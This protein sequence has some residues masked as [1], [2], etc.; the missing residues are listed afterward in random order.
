MWMAVLTAAGVVYLTVGF[1]GRR[2]PGPLARAHAR[3]PALTGFNSCAR[4]HG[5]WFG[6]MAE[7]CLECHVD[8]GAQTRRG[9][10]LHGA[11]G[12]EA[13]R[14]AACHS[15]HHGADFPM[16]NRI[17][18]VRAGIENPSH[19]D[20]AL[21][22]W[23][24]AGRHLELS[25]SEC[26]EHAAAAVLPE[27]AK[28]YLGLDRTCAGCHEDP[29]GGLLTQDCARCHRQD[30]FRALQA[31]D[32]DRAL[33]LEGGHAGVTCRTC[34][35]GGEA[36]ALEA[37]LGGSAS[38]RPRTCLDCHRS[39]H[40]EGFVQGAAGPAAVAVDAGCGVCHLAEHSSFRP[41]DLSVTS[42]QHA[43]SG[44]PLEPPHAEIACGACHRPEKEPFGARYPGREAD[45]CAACHADPHD[46]Q[47]R[48]ASCLDCHDRLRF[49]PHGFTAERHAATKLPL[50][51][52]H[53][54]T[55][56]HSCHRES[57]PGR[58]RIFA[59]T[60][61]DCEG[62]HVDAHRGFFGRFA[63]EEEPARCAACHATTSFREALPFD[64]PRWTGFALRGAHAQDACESCHQRTR[65][66]DR[67]GRTFGEVS[68]RFGRVENCGSCHRDV[69]GGRFDGPGRPREVEGRSSCARCHTETSFRDFPGGFDHATWTGFPL[70]GAHG[71]VGCTG[72][73]A[74]LRR[75]DAQGRTWARAQGARCA[76]CH[77]DPHAGQ[78]RVSGVTDCRRC[79]RSAMSFSDLTFRHDVDSRFRLGQAHAKVACAACHTPMRFGDREIVR[80]RPIP[81]RCSDCHE[82]QKD[83]LRRGG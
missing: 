15:E 76:D 21:V 13:E 17:S 6:S 22:G 8:I 59:G 46:G 37:L 32:H 67:A 29:H 14:C 61:A 31:V 2:A 82:S 40:S 83:P 48:D 7:S 19:F 36:H 80:Y 4:C 38:P 55:E 5:G 52:G 56:C 50:T 16:V 24:M 60:P 74:P 26:H 51:G 41:G 20:H 62:C 70:E 77:D 28:R 71:T 10:G 81:H 57:A 39:P 12:E 3:V 45:D 63:K 66:P 1:A 49:Q 42:A 65:E 47:F 78:F 34:H 72:C 43:A 27:G 75:P 53:L 79:H 23:P 9:A 44:F 73:H 18:F 25:C 11:L 35:A 33:P 69:H 54:E 64:H 58:A 30:S 68:R